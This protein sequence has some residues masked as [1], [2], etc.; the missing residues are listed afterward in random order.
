MGEITDML[1]THIEESP[2]TA[3]ARSGQVVSV[4]HAKAFEMIA[5]DLIVLRELMLALSSQV[6]ALTDLVTHAT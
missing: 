6:D 4:E 1:S 5:A 2:L 3:I